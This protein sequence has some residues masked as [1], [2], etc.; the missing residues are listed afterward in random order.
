[1][2]RAGHRSGG[3]R[4][5]PFATL[6]GTRPFPRTLP[7]SHSNS[8]DSGF[9]TWSRFRI[10]PDRCGA[11]RAADRG[12]GWEH[13][14]RPDLLGIK[15]GHLRPVVD[16]AVVPAQT[17]LLG[18]QAPR[19]PLTCPHPLPPVLT[20][21]SALLGPARPPGPGRS[22]AASG[23]LEPGDGGDTG[24]R[25]LS[26]GGRRVGA[27]PAIPGGAPWG[28]FGN[29]RAALRCSIDNIPGRC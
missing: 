16:Q 26:G 12:C 2:R 18:Y 11:P 8:W 29:S 24:Q 13:E 27:D 4:A 14:R 9:A 21:T 10:S 17:R 15:T 5:G 6:A 25:A 28:G 19:L 7:L 23:H 3:H 22:G 1:M 20:T